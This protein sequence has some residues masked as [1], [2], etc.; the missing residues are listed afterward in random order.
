MTP[1]PHAGQAETLRV[2]VQV[3]DVQSQTLD[4]TLPAYLPARDLTQRIARDAG[5]NAFWPDGR[6]RLYWLRARG[7]LMTDDERLMDLGVVPNELVHLLPE[8]P[9]GTGVVEREP[10][11]PENQGYAA[12]GTIALV[13][14]VLA[15]V[16][17][18]IGWGLALSVSR[19]LFV[20]TLPG[21]GLGILC[22]SMARH[23]F[24]GDGWKA[25][26]PAV[27]MAI[28]ILL[29][30]LSLMLPVLLGEDP[31]AVFSESIA[32]LVTALAGVLFAWLA[33]WGAVEPLQKLQ[34][35]EEVQQ[36]VAAIVGCDICGQGAEP[37]VRMDCP[38]GCGKVFHTGCH[39]ARKAVFRGE[40]ASCEVCG[41]QVRK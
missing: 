34:P 40:A 26:V 41:Q 5:L 18:S 16:S 37:H 24:G 3:I 22:C 10:D 2:R 9:A 19:S 38:Y 15:V 29:V 20:T 17:W 32:G 35:I 31:G 14:T 28:A 1:S 21:F 33:W 7:R 11:Y 30:A 25:R 23:L 39:A 4:L 8:P 12:R 13:L 6:R 27:G 36:D